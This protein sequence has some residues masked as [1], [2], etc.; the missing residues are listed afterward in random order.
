MIEQQVYSKETKE[1]GVL[2]YVP[3]KTNHVSPTCNVSKAVSFNEEAFEGESLARYDS[4]VVKK[5]EIVDGNVGILH[6]NHESI[7]VVTPTTKINGSMTIEEYMQ[8][9][10][11]PILSYRGYGCEMQPLHAIASSGKEELDT[12]IFEEYGGKVYVRNTKGD[13]VL[14]LNF[15]LSILERYM[16]ID[17]NGKEEHYVKLKINQNNSEKIMDVPVNKLDSG[18][19]LITKEHP[20]C[21]I[22]PDSG[23]HIQWFKVYVSQI[24]EKSINETYEQKKYLNAGWNLGENGLMH[25]YS[26]L[27]ANCCSEWSLSV[28]EGVNCGALIKRVQGLLGLAPL[29]ITLPLFLHAHYGYILKLFEDAGYHEEYALVIAGTTGSKKTSVARVMFEH[30]GNGIINFTST[31]RAMELELAKRHDAMV[32]IDDLHSQRDKDTLAKLQHIIRQLGDSTA[33]KRSVN[34]G[35]EQECLS[36]RCGVVITAESDITQLE[37][38]GI[39]RTL[40]VNVDEKTFNSTILSS[41]QEEINVARANGKDNFMEQYLTAFIRF[42]E[43]NYNEI[44][45]FLGREPNSVP[46]SKFARQ[47]TIGKI[48]VQLSYVIL[49]FWHANGVVESEDINILLTQW[50]AIIQEVLQ[51]NEVR[52]KTSAPH[53]MFISAI[54]EGIASKK[55]SIVRDKKAFEN[56]TS[57]MAGFWNEDDSVLKLIP[58]DA[59][60]FV[61]S[62]YTKMGVKFIEPLQGILDRLYK[63][64]LLEVYDAKTINLS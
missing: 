16:L 6:F 17:V 63:A 23:K 11:G 47:R 37:S 25:Y 10:R 57:S 19:Q 3:E 7:P 12:S 8:W 18:P 55:L 61:S 29:T 20:E 28:L 59:Y 33:K 49:Y 32:I 13:S 46:Y 44:V 27:D 5:G 24:Y 14:L 53:I 1:K 56:S 51:V 48:L 52:G 42:I 22:Y 36:V 26:G 43:R 31:S 64:N 62:Y 41:Y 40:V 45:T 39:L 54:M 9:S 21:S 58:S 60:A 35:R 30:F 38:S 4:K 34:Q 15:T 2:R 50:G